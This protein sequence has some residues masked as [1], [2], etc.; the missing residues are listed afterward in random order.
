MATAMDRAFAYV[1]LGM[2]L[3]PQFGD[4]RGRVSV[5]QARRRSGREARMDRFKA[6]VYAGFGA[7]IVPWTAHIRSGRCHAAARLRHGQR[8]GRPHVFGLLQQQPDH[9]SSGCRRS[10]RRCAARSRKW[11]R[12]R[13]QDAVRIRRRRH[14][15]ATQADQW[16]PR[17][18]AAISAPSTMRVRRRPVRAAFGAQIRGRHLSLAGTGFASCRRV[19]MQ[20]TTLAPSRR[21]RRRTRCC[22]RRHSASRWRNIIYYAALTRGSALRFG[23]G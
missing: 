2:I 4:Y 6:R 12:V 14:D 17:S 20:A 11:P 10:A 7:F 22:G 13:T 19:S 9:Q 21:H 16:T 8:D 23:I 1:M 18:D 3:G 15:H 5:R